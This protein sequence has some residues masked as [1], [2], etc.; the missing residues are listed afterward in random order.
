MLYSDF[1]RIAQKRRLLAFA[2]KGDFSSPRSKRNFSLPRSFS[3]S[4]NLLLT[5]SPPS[6]AADCGHT[7]RFTRFTPPGPSQLDDASSWLSK[8]R[9]RTRR[10][11]VRRGI[12]SAVMSSR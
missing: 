10:P 6:A 9:R 8:R 5:R 2:L 7:E 12:S 3:L 4:S 1:D 11:S